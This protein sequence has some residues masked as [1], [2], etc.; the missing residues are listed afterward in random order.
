MTTLEIKKIHSVSR[1]ALE[2]IVPGYS[3]I[4]IYKIERTEANDEV[5]FKFSKK[6]LSSPYNKIHQYSD[7]KLLDEYNAV[8]AQGLSYGAFYEGQCVGILLSEIQSWNSTLIVREFGV[9]PEMRKQG[10]GM[11]L[12]EHVT[13]E[14]RTANLRSILCETQNTNAGAIEFY[15]KQGF[16][17]DGLDL[18][19]YQNKDQP[20]REIA[21]F[22][23]KG[24]E[25]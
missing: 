13:K 1:E 17:I 23:R 25:K 22:L 12:M 2:K 18:S 16:E 19:F 5:T 9:N 21:I 14:A 3:T 8:A 4:H 20:K 24:L 7:S 10:V 11:A 15:K 6:I